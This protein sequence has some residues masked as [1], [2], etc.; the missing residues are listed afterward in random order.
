ML[1]RLLGRVAL[2]VGDG[3]DQVDVEPSGLLRKGL[4]ALLALQA[5]E[6]VDIDRLID[7]L[8]GA[9]PPRAANNSLQAHVSALRRVLP[10]EVVVASTGHGYLLQVTRDDVDALRAEALVDRARRA[11]DATSALDAAGRALTLWRGPALADVRGLAALAA[12]GERLDA[13][14]LAAVT[15]SITA[16]LALGESAGLVPELRQL[17]LEHPFDESLHAALM[18]A[19]YRAGRQT[20]ALAA[21][22]DLRTLL[23][24]ELGI[25]PGAGVRDLHDAMLRHD[26]ALLTA[27]AKAP[28]TPRAGAA[29]LTPRRPPAPL[30][31]FVGREPESEQVRALLAKHRLVTLLG[32]GGIGKTRLA[33][34]TAQAEHGDL[35]AVAMLAD[36]SPGERAADRIV[37]EF[38]EAFGLVAEPDQ[39]LVATLVAALGERRALLV[40]DNVEHVL[41]QAAGV[42]AQVLDGAPDVRVLVTSREALGVPGEQCLPLGPLR[43]SAAVQLFVERAAA[44][45]PGFRLDDDNAA[46]VADLC[47]TLDGLPLALELAA[48]RLAVLS[49]H[50]LSRALDSGIALVSTGSATVAH[51][52]R[53]L[54]D[55]VQWSYDL[56]DGDERH[57]LRCFAGFVE[58]ATVEGLAHV[59]R[60][61][62]PVLGSLPVLSLVDK[63]LLLRDPA[64]T[65]NSA[66]LRAH[67]SIAAFARARLTASADVETVSRRHAEWFRDVL[68][69][70]GAAGLTGVDV[71][72]L[73]AD[74]A[75]VDAALRWATDHDIE[76]GLEIAALG[77]WFWYRTGHV[78]VP[79]HLLDDLLRRPV[80][81][82]T[83]HYGAALAAAGYLA[84]L[85]D[86]FAAATSFAQRA[87]AQPDETGVAHAMAMGVISRAAGDQGDFA[88]A[89]EAAVD[90]VRRYTDAG[91]AWGAVWSRRCLAVATL[92]L[93]DTRTAAE[94]A[95]R[96]L[97][98]YTALGDSWGIAGT[99]DML[100]AIALRDGEPE[101]A[102]GWAEEAVRSHRDLDDVSG[103]RYALQHRAEIA[104][105]S[106]DVPL[107]RELA[108]ESLELARSH[109]Y[110]VGAMQALLL[111]A[112]HG[113]PAAAAE[114]FRL[115][116]ALGDTSG[117]QRARALGGAPP[118]QL[119]PDAATS[120]PA[121]GS[122][123]G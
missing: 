97:R 109:G 40:V 6:P 18:T 41:P 57:A 93:G 56:L 12:Q 113:E 13:V 110:R 105:A 119:A 82:K 122:E 70:R 24:A 115:A 30:S 63:S 94:E 1:V 4:L 58:G 54:E 68:R 36:I 72:D 31:S 50:E 107:A 23:A 42:I 17:V 48:P 120:S 39:P 7:A 106:G 100:A 64:S 111:L 103:L 112:E 9:Q 83:A 99:L 80:P 121:T 32:A 52:H 14:H 98:D 33:L 60:P 27:T 5:G 11:G 26:P 76:L 108:R 8:W 114:A 77:W 2:T 84:W 81:L 87:L 20:D 38:A 75:N 88:T 104:V 66:R 44:R 46:A 65:R 79:R 43:E 34:E 85:K 74:A 59:C 16:R 89:R 15:A 51:R 123:I 117:E 101:R 49:P 35:V 62:A 118:D 29:G 86:D 19:L 78:D 47:R 61:D 71:R 73:S 28:A 25:E 53:S 10:A 95:G 22:R 91:D 69:E 67:A 90:S 45:D 3:A 37:T 96:C 102:T 21:F 116:R 55:A 92:Y